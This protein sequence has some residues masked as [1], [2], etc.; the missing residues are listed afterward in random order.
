MPSSDSLLAPVLPVAWQPVLAPGA[1]AAAARGDAFARGQEEGG[2]IVLPPHALRF[3]AL[4]AVSPATVRVLILGQD[5]YHRVGQA[6]GLAFSVSTGVALPPSL[7]NIFAELHA[8][9]GV[10]RTNTDLSDWARQGVLLLNTSLSVSEG[11]AGSH[12]GQ[13]WEEFAVHVIDALSR[14]DEPLA[15]V[16]W[17]NPAQKLAAGR[18]D[19]T[20]HL[21]VASPHPSPLSAYRGFLGSRPFSRI[22]AWLQ[23]HHQTPV[24]WAGAAPAR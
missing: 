9:L 24:D 7:R 17:G 19:A 20:R 14:R 16:L 21:V 13:G 18:I 12:V 11:R 22:N 6:D 8:D 4:E 3:A 1:R 2:D 15:F 5:P 23:T 10:T